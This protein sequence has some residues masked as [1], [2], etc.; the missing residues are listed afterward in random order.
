MSESK[1]MIE[2]KVIEIFSK[3]SKKNVELSYEIEGLELD[4]LEFVKLIIELEDSFDIEI[5]DETL[6]VSNGVKIQDFYDFIN[7]RIKK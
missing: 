6:Y 7:D 4:S 1:E 2:K 3:Y 5:D